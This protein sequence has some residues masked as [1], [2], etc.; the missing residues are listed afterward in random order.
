MAN[1]KTKWKVGNGR[2][3]LFWHDNW[4]IQG[5]LINNP[6]YGNWANIC[7]RKFG[8]KVRDYRIDQG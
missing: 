7:I 1:A 3:I 8:L 4:L 6:I 2:D 5:P